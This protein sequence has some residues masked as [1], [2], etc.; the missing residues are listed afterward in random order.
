MSAQDGAKAEFRNGEF[1]PMNR[2]G[3]SI[4]TPQIALCYRRVG[5]CGAR[6]QTKRHG[7]AL[8]SMNNTDKIPFTNENNKSTEK[9]FS[10]NRPPAHLQCC[11]S[12]GLFSRGGCFS[13]E[14]SGLSQSIAFSGTTNSLAYAVMN[15]STWM[16]RASR[17]GRSALQ[18]SRLLLARL[19]T[20]LLVESNCT[21]DN[22]CARRM[23][24]QNKAQHAEDA[25]F[26]RNA[27]RFYRLDIEG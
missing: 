1:R 23:R 2:V 22:I 10:T 19:L 16:A 27:V 8:C 15:K 4:V 11:A 17:A 14:C 24:S 20:F 7:L 13:H 25:V 26:A 12:I 21:H 3:S 9:I 18:C 5:I 6:N